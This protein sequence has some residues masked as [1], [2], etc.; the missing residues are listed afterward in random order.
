V[1]RLGRICVNVTTM[2]SLLL[3]AATLVLWVRSYWVSDQYRYPDGPDAQVLSTWGMLGAWGHPPSPVPLTF[4]FP[5]IPRGYHQGRPFTL[6]PPCGS[7][8]EVGFRGG[9]AFAGV[10]W[11]RTDGGPI[12]NG[13][14]APFYQAT[15]PHWLVALLFGLLPATRGLRRLARGPR[16]VHGQCRT[17]G[18]DLR[19]TS[20]RCPE[21]GTVRKVATRGDSAA[22]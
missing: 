22:K 19:A 9:F 13:Y 5:E 1:R 16:R 7:A 18:Y 17:C 21:C 2:L 10:S 3:C 15:V 11:F 12:P 14:T 8:S 4:G 6:G 20:E